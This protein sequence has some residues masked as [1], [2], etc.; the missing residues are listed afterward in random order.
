MREKI[1]D[2]KEVL[3]PG[4]FTK[5]CKEDIKVPKGSIAHIH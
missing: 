4:P 2:E 1:I 5:I 3:P